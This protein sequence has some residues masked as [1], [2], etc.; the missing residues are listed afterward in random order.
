M[1][2]QC[3]EWQVNHV[4]RQGNA[5]AHGLAK[6]ALNIQQEVVWTVNFPLCIWDLVNT[7]QGSH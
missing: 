5:V 3:R 1:L 2:S 7:E 4:H 6:L